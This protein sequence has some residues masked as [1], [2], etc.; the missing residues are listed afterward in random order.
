M[1]AVAADT[2]ETVDLAGKW[3][4][5]DSARRIPA[6]GDLGGEDASPLAVGMGEDMVGELDNHDILSA[7]CKRGCQ[8]KIF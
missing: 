6:E 5:T 2:L 4:V 3:K 7:A 1:E 8:E